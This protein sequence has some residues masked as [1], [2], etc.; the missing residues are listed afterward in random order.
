MNKRCVHTGIVLLVTCKLTGNIRISEKR[1][2]R[3]Q[4]C[5]KKHACTRT[6]TH[7]VGMVG[8]DFFYD[9]K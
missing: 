1:E 4:G 8:A 7:K 6:R 3:H 9:W 2:E 5:N